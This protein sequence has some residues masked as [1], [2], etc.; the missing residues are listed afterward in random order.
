ML[1]SGLQSTPIWDSMAFFY[2]QS[3]S[4]TVLYKWCNE[5][6]EHADI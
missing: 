6:E 2:Q 1:R 5:L 4:R 3:H